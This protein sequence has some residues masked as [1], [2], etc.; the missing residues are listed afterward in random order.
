MK[1][2]FFNQILSIILIIGDYWYNHAINFAGDHSNARITRPVNY[3][4]LETENDDIHPR[5]TYTYRNLYYIGKSRAAHV[6][7]NPFSR[8]TSHNRLDMRLISWH[9]LRK[10]RHLSQKYFFFFLF[11]LFSLLFVLLLFFFPFFLYL[12]Y[13]SHIFFFLSYVCASVGVYIKLCY[14]SIY[15]T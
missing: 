14:I 11:L 9:N 2:T 13:L 4:T 6:D 8:E 3:T 5:A 12:C 10:W 7:F 1:K 15:I